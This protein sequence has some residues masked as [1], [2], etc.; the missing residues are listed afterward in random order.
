MNAVQAD[1]MLV[2]LRA[3]RQ[4]L[5]RAAL[6][7]VPEPVEQHVAMLLHDAPAGWI[8]RTIRTPTRHS[9]GAFGSTQMMVVAPPSSK[10]TPE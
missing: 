1:Q 4:L 7:T 3:I 9:G 10:L 8:V 6:G 2:E 5:E